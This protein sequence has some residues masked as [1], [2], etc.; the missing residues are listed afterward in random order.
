MIRTSGQPVV[1]DMRPT[2][3]LL[4]GRSL[5]ALKRRELINLFLNGAAHAAAQ[6]LPCL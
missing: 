4:H 5:N 3:S 2:G 1:S 6:A